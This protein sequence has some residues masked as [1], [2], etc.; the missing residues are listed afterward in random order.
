MTQFLQISLIRKRSFESGTE[1][2][3]KTFVGHF[4]IARRK[5]TLKMIDL[6]YMLHKFSLA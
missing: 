2:D 5:N 3:N 1:L 4:G 6:F